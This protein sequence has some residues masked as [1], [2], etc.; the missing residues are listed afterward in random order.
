MHS[1]IFSG[2]VKHSR[3]VPVGHAFQYRLF[4]M[5]VAIGML[6]GIWGA[7]IAGLTSRSY[8]TGFRVARTLKP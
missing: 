3:A 6:A 4:M 1:C 7:A 2:Q 5:A 8:L